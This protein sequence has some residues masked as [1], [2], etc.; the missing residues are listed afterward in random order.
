[1]TSL[2]HISNYKT[3][4]KSAGILMKMMHEAQD[5]DVD[6]DDDLMDEINKQH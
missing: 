6:I 1:M 5:L 2:A 4:L 3:I